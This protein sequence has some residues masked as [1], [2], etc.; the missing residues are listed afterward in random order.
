[1]RLLVSGNSKFNNYDLF[2][3]GVGVAID[4]LTPRKEDGSPDTDKD[5]VIEIFSAGP[6]NINNYT[7]QF[8]NVSE[9]IL[10]SMGYK[11]KFHR[12]P[13]RTCVSN[14][15]KW[16]IERVVLFGVTNLHA[17]PL[18]ATAGL[19]GISVKAY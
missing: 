12:Y 14:L 18:S 4:E 16:E 19:S 6:V 9:R 8:A 17:E 2:L 11:V 13:Y 15:Q 1:M 5:N 7:A 10:K 3:R